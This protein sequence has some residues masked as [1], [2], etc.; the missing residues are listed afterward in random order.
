MGQPVQRPLPRK[1][2][3]PGGYKNLRIEHSEL[4]RANWHW[5]IWLSANRDFTC[6]TFLA[7]YTGGEIKRITW[8]PD[9]TESVFEMDEDG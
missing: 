8:H 2:G 7:L 1:F 9:G 5:R 6:G 4:G 3:V